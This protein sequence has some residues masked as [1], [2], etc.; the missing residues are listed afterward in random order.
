MGARH[1]SELRQHGR[2]RAGHRHRHRD[3]RQSGDGELR[4][5]RGRTAPHE[6][7]AGEEARPRLGAGEELPRVPRPAPQR[8]EEAPAAE[9]LQGRRRSR[10]RPHGERAGGAPQRAVHR[11]GPRAPRGGERRVREPL[12]SGHEPEPRPHQRG[13]RQPRRH[14]AR[15]GGRQGRRDRHRHRPAP[16]VLQPRGLQLSRRLPEERSALRRDDDAEGHRGAGVL[17]QRQQDRPERPRLHGGPGAR[18]PRRGHHRRR[19]VRGRWRHTGP[20]AGHALRRRARS[21]ARQLQRLPRPRHERALRG[22]RAGGGGRRGRRHGRAQPEPRR[23]A[24]ERQRE[25]GRARGGA[26]RR[27][28]RRRGLRRR[29]RQCGPGRQYDR[30][31]RRGRARHHRRRVEQPALHRHPD[32]GRRPDVRVGARRLRHV[33][34]PS[35]RP[36]RSRRRRTAAR[37]RSPASRGA[38]RSSTE[39]S[40]RSRR[41]SATRRR[42]APWASSS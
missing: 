9:R 16:P 13:R 36:S 42:R 39:G 28:R 3:A 29:R 15:R 34:P 32:H 6:A 37:L 24:P 19:R 25:P 10:V 14:G 12:P 38:S 7:R 5:P 35:P 2:R 22:H 21:A 11:R 40:A 23:V 18:L 1:R 41:R 17:L 4:R 26:E 30:V 27:G 8:P 31:A 20:G 33:H